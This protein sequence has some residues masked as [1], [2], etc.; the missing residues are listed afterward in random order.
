VSDDVTSAADVGPGTA[1]ERPAA[2]RG[3]PRGPRRTREE[4]REELLDAA[5]RAIRRA[6]PQAS[7]EELAAEA[8]ITK[9]I[10]YS[11]FGDRAGLA[12]ALAERTSDMLISTLSDSLH[13]AV[14]TGNPRVVISSAFEAF[15][16]FIEADPSI[17]RFLV[18]SALDSP[19]P[20]TSR[21]VTSIAAQISLQLTRAL[22]LADADVKPAEAW[23]LAI[24]GMG[25]V[26]AE[27]WLDRQSLSKD[28]VVEYLTLLVWSGLAGAG[29]DRLQAPADLAAAG[30]LAVDS[31]ASSSGT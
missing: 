6:G 29:L 19:N 28:Q 2:K 27:W 10:L 13:S 23:G 4:R 3:R 16:S 25:F 24:V 20:V 11:H 8:G 14:R 26:G 9:P 7:M 17:Y 1:T 18:R 12:E 15:C 30:D 31:P 5:E 21:L 22:K